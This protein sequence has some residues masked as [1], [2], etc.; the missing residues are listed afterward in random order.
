VG[1]RSLV[2]DIGR[3]L[4]LATLCHGFA[5][6][7]EAVDQLRRLHLFSDQPRATVTSVAHLL[8]ESYGGERWVDPLLPDLLGERLVYGEIERGGGELLD[9]TLGPANAD[10]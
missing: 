6:E 9:L 5:D 4:A 3:G 10:G 8:H 1:T 7:R 2:R